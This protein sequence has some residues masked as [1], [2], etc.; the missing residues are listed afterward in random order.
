MKIVIE[1]E[2]DETEDSY[3]VISVLCNGERIK[4]EMDAIGRCGYKFW[5][6]SQGLPIAMQTLNL[7]QWE[8]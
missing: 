3:N 6:L 7:V 4:G 2:V 5:D 8:E 1:V